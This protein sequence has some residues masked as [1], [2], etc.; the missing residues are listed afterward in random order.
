MRL[1]MMDNTLID[2]IEHVILMQ[3]YV[4]Q[5]W[6]EHLKVYEMKWLNSLATLISNKH[7][8]FT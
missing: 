2:I 6:R 3:K 8:G 1:Q 4:L 7:R 5:I